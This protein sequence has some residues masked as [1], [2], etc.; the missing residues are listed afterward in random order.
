MRLMPHRYVCMVYER[1]AVQLT[2]KDGAIQLTVKD[3]AIQLTV[4]DGATQRRWSHT[5]RQA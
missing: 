2:L 4:E 1:G 3:G 5:Q